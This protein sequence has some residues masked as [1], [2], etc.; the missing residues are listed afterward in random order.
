LE[1]DPQ[2]ALADF[3]QALDLAPDRAL[4]QLLK[5]RAG[6]QEALG[7]E[8]ASARDL[9]A[10]SSSD[11][12]YEDGTG[13]GLMKAIGGDAL[14]GYVQAARKSER[15]RLVKEGTVTAVGYCRACREV[16]ELDANLRCSISPSHP[17]PRRVQFAMPDETAQAKEA[18]TVELEK[19][20]RGR[21]NCLIVVAAL[22]GLLVVACMAFA[23]LSQNRTP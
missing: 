13:A 8:E 19:G 20:R 11:G 9:L 14:E 7:M 1:R 3:G 6:L 23:L 5:E 21:R 15:K 22:V 16:V 17:K 2:Q 12:A 10:Y 4:P 18:M